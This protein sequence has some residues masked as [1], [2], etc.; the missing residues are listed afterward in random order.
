MPALSPP[1]RKNARE[2]AAGHFHERGRSTLREKASIIHGNR[3]YG[4][5][6]G[7]LAPLTMTYG[8]ATYS[9]AAAM[10]PTGLPR[11]PTRRS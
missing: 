3:A 10:R 2:N 9:T 8:F 11:S 6:T 4:R 5:S 7:V 1:I